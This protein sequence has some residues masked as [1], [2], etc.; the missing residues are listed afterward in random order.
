MWS[1]WWEKLDLSRFHRFSK[2]LQNSI[3]FEGYGDFDLSQQVALTSFTYMRYGWS[4]T[5]SKSWF[6][7]ISLRL[8]A[9]FISSIMLCSTMWI[10]SFYA[11]LI[12]FN[13][14]IHLNTFYVN[15]IINY[16]HKANTWRN[17]QKAAIAGK[18]PYQFSV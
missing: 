18:F 6:Q 13:Q 5:N 11:I 8:P 12:L 15:F 16:F 2:T 9:I 3:I 4:R 1:V 14:R 7:F 17:Y 10:T